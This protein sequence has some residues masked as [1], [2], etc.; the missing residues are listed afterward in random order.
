MGNIGLLTYLLTLELM[1]GQLTRMYILLQC[2][3]K[4]AQN[5]PHINFFQKSYNN[6]VCI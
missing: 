5:P 1:D 2:E 3:G 6:D 4:L